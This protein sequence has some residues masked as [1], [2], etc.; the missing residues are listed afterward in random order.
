MKVA[1][2]SRAENVSGKEIM[3]LE[4]GAGLRSSGHEVVF[5]TSHWN[6]GAYQARLQEL[7]FGSISLHLGTISATLS[8]NCLRMTSAQVLRLPLLWADYRSFLRKEEPQ[9]II[10]TSWHHLLLLWAFLKTDRDWFWVHEVLPDMSHYRW[11]FSRLAS[12]LRGFIAVSNAVKESLQKL[13]I[14]EAKIQVVP[15][16]LRDIAPPEGRFPRVEGAVR[17]GIVGQVAEWKG[18]R[19]LFDAFARCLAAHPG[20]ELHVF[21][22]GTVDEVTDLKRRAE[23]LGISG[24]IAWHGFVADRTSI[25]EEID[26][27]AIP[28]CFDEPFGLTAVEAGLFRL[29]VVA[30]RRGGLPDIIV[31][32][33]TGFLVGA[34]DLP[35]LSSRLDELIVDLGL[36]DRMGKAAREHVEVRFGRERFVSDFV[37]LLS[38]NSSTS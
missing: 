37:R 3:T 11:V 1:I 2:V 30:F 26:I 24:Q 23:S 9:Q 21:G 7:D 8:R 16:G 35:Q 12:R 6:D 5:V 4:L 10:H 22:S 36:R 32:G 18:H 33:Q 19:W 14:P 15:N 20:I 17:I 31:D 27:C 34:G 25:F 29:P 13:G 28:S 38:Q